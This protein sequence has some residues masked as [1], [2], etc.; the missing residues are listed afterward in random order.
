MGMTRADAWLTRSRSRRLG[1][2][3]L[4]CFPYA[5]G[6]ASAYRTWPDRWRRGSYRQRT[7]RSR[8]RWPSDSR[9]TGAG[10]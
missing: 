10:V 8:V 4:L 1:R 9:R 6:R 5:G 2:L 7:A 3:Q